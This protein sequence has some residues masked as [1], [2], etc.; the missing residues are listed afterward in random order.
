M[1]ARIYSVELFEVFTGRKGK[2]ESYFE[3]RP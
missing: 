1:S 3:D 2:V